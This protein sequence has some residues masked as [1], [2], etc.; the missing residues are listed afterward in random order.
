M[1][2]PAAKLKR[3]NKGVAVCLI[4][5]ATSDYLFEDFTHTFEEGDG[6]VGFREGVVTFTWF[7]DNDHFS[8]TPRMVA[9]LEAGGEDGCERVRGTLKGPTD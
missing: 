5:Q 3:G 2:T 6:V 1:K 9:L 4:S 7:R 8:G